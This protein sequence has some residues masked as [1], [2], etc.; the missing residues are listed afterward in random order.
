MT[1]VDFDVK[2]DVVSQ[3]C[4][5]ETIVMAR[6]QSILSALFHMLRQRYILAQLEFKALKSELSGR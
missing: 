2:F 4:K 6:M 1:F 5:V 3:K